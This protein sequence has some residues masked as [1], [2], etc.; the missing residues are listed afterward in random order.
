MVFISSPSLQLHDNVASS[1]PRNI[2]A[3]NETILTLRLSW[4]A[5]ETPNGI[6]TGYRVS[7]SVLHALACSSHPYL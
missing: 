6:I 5:P 4:I 1:P 7:L 2:V 3:V